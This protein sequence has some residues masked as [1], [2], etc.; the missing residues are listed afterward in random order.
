[1]ASAFRSPDIYGNADPLIAAALSPALL[2][3][4]DFIYRQHLELPVVF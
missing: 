4:R 1:M 3:H 2:A